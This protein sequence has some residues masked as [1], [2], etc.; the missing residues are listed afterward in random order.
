MKNAFRILILKLKGR[1]QWEIQT[2]LRWEANIIV[3]FK[4]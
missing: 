2:E 1:R 4:Y 3:G